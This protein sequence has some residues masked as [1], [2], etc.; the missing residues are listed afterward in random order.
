MMSFPHCKTNLVHKIGTSGI[1]NVFFSSLQGSTHCQRLETASQ[2]SP[3]WN[4]R[5]R[6][7]S[8][9]WSSTRK[10]VRMLCHQ[11][12]RPTR[13]PWPPE[14]EADEAKGLRTSSVEVVVQAHVEAEVDSSPVETSEDV[15]VFLWT[16]T[17]LL[18]KMC[19][20]V[21]CSWIG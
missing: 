19:S 9:S 1:Q 21:S 13:V 6:R 11:R 8:S 17:K 10:R 20:S 16:N 3:M 5:R 18:Y 15:R 4:C 14:R 7:P 12:R 2:R